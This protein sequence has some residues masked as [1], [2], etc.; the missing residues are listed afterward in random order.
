MGPEDRAG[1]SSERPVG[2]GPVIAR[3]LTG[4]L[5]CIGCGY[6]LRGLS[7]R[8][9]CPECGIPVRATIL[10][11]IDPMADELAPIPRPRLVAT[12]LV[13]WAVGV[14]LAV[15]AVAL[16]RGAEIGREMLGMAWWPGLAPFM[17]TAGL[18]ASGIG[19]GVA[20][21]RPHARVGRAAAVRAALGVA[22][23]VPLTLVYFN[24]YGRMD[25]SS[26]APFLSPGPQEVDRSLLRLALFVFVAIVVWGVRVHTRALALRS[27]VVRTGR[28]DRQ[29][30]SALLASFAVAAGGDALHLASGLVGGGAAELVSTVGTVLQAVGSVLVVVGVSNVV[31]DAWRLWPVIVRPGVGLGDVLENNRQRARRTGL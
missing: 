14:W 11:V 24:I 22:G 6:N 16:M 31:L 26:P 9:M 18:V 8:E 20:L 23:Y 2:S 21:I 19:A 4:D 15:A 1:P 5:L 12:G 25:R 28:V 29:S 7:I 13:A 3:Q 30:M 27:V 17:G 10:G